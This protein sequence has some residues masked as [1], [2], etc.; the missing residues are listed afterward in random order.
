MKL[1]PLTG[2]PPMPMQVDWPSP[3]AVVWATASQVR[4]PER[5]TTPIRPQ[6]RQCEETMPRNRQHAIASL[7]Q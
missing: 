3:A 5:E 1:V 2:S 7:E 6:T 4:V